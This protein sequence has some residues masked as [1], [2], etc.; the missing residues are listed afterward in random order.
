MLHRPNGVSAFT[1]V[2]LSLVPVSTGYAAALDLATLTRASEAAEQAIRTA[3][4]RYLYN[5]ASFESPPA[6]PEEIARQSPHLAFQLEVNRAAEVRNHLLWDA[7]RG[8]WKLETADLRDLRRFAATERVRDQVSLTGTILVGEKDYVITASDVRRT[9]GVCPLPPRAERSPPLNLGVVPSR[10]LRAQAAVTF[11]NVHRDGRAVTV[12]AI[13]GSSFG[14]TFE[15][16]PGFESRYR[17][18]EFRTAE[19]RVY[20]EKQASD[21][22]TIDGQ[23]Y[24]HHYEERIWDATGGLLRQDEITV[25][26]AQFNAPLDPA[27]LQIQI[28]ADTNVKRACWRRAGRNGV[29]PA[30]DARSR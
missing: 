30:H 28:P 1:A 6:T 4:V 12:V 19:G 21:Y 23:P 3:D 29:R 20:K 10:I 26:A 5:W 25:E 2:V 9:A 18:A 7:G 15:L 27:S 8:R 13:K 17:K 22:R 16:D 14:A 24:P 11:R